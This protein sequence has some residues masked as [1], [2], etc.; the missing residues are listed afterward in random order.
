VGS[1]RFNGLSAAETLLTRMGLLVDCGEAIGIS[2]HSIHRTQLCS[3]KI[4]SC[5]AD[6]TFSLV[7]A[8]CAW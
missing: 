8:R 2:S 6:I 4:A 3:V 1:R 5:I 7:I